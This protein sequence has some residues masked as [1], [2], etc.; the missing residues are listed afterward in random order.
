[1]KTITLTGMMGAGKSAV[2]K[3]LAEKF[4]CK[5][6]DI[7]T[8]IET[9]ENCSISEIFENKGEEYFRTLE[10]NTIL[11]NTKPENQV[12]ALGGG[13]FE[14]PETQ[15]FLLKNSTVI[16]LKTQPETI[17]ERIKTDLTRPLLKN[18]MS[19]EKIKNIIISRKKNYEKAA[20]IIST[21]SK[22]IEQIASEI[23]GV[24]ND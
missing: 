7:D 3:L 5:L 21:D 22:S 16:Y 13:A 2:A 17:Y 20:Y 8:L 10:K 12:I 14:N 4:N 11:Q 1:M 24:Y 18:N 19:I 15:E 23:T 6:L 9:N